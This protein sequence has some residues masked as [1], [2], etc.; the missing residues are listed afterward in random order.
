MMPGA[1]VN[2]LSFL[3]VGL[4]WRALGLLGPDAGRGAF[5]GAGNAMHAL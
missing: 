3:L 4:V 1:R 5:N 2:S